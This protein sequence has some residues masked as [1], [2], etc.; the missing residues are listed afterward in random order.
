MKTNKETISWQYIGNSIQGA[1]HIRTKLDNQDALKSSLWKAQTREIL[2]MAV[3]DGHGGSKYF[4]S[5]HGAKFAVDIAVDTLIKVNKEMSDLSSIK[6]FLEEQLPKV[7]V[8]RWI[9]SVNEHLAQNPISDDE[10]AQLEVKE[11]KPSAEIVKKNNLLAYGAT[12]VSIVLTESYAIY[13]QLGDGDILIVG[14]NGE[15]TRPYTSDERLIAN[16]TTS[17]CS[18]DAWRDFRSA[19]QV[20]SGNPPALILISTDGY[21]NS[22]QNEAAFEV[23]GTDILEMIRAQ[24]LEKIELELE[25]WLK[26]ASELGSGDDITLA[27]AY[28]VDKANTKWLETEDSRYSDGDNTPFATS[29]QID[30]TVMEKLVKKRCFSKISGRKT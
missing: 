15:V 25:T 20:F 9:E 27:L 7:L 24:G 19:F 29:H 30:N 28:R 6:R 13:L 3:A 26:E 22:F 12:I 14:E 1:S 4:R 23:V 5:K 10:L 21:A 16:E 2:C 11:N 17:L 8:Q 18:K